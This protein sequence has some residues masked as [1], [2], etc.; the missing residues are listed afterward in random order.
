MTNL[1]KFSHLSMQDQLLIVRVLTLILTIK[2]GLRLVPFRLMR[3]IVARTAIPARISLGCYSL[4]RITWAVHVVGRRFTTNC[5]VQAITAYI[6]L[7]RHGH[8]ANLR[9]GVQYDNDRSFAAHAWV[10]S[11]AYVVIG[12]LPDLSRYTALPDVLPLPLRNQRKEP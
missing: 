8:P 5:L 2:V 6:L 3:H 7:R 10:E 11:Q 9:I 1:A 4:E 12:A